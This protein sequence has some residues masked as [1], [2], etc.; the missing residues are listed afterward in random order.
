M[1]TLSAAL[2]IFA[3]PELVNLL[4]RRERIARVPIAANGLGRGVREP[5]RHKLLVLRSSIVG[6]FVGM[7]PGIG[8]ARKRALLAHFGSAKA[9]SRAGLSDLK[10]APGISDAMAETIHAFFHARG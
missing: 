6:I 9:V 10:A 8:A 4:A 3:L 2:G 1:R 5:F 7:I